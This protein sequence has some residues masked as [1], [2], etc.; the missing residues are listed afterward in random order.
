M[1]KNLDISKGSITSEAI[2]LKLG[3]MIGRQDAHEL[4]HNCY[5][6]S[7]TKKK[8]FVEVLKKNKKIKKYLSS[9]TIENLCNPKNYIGL[10]VSFATYQ[11]KLAKKLSN[12]LKNKIS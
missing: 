7:F 4:I 11:G 6:Y 10:S 5:N 3:E 12:K 2:M 9:S 1:L 8:N